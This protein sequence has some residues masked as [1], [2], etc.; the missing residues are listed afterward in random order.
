M[1]VKLI[2]Y[3]FNPEETVNSAAA[4]CYNSKPNDKI[5]EHCLKSRHFSVLEFA[6]FDFLI[7]GISRSCSHQFVR[8]RVGISYAQQSQ[9]HVKFEEGY[10]VVIPHTISSNE[11]ALKI[12]N[13][14]HKKSEESYKK[15][16][17]IGIPAED[18]RYVIENAATT[19]IRANMNGRCLI[20]F[21]S[22]RL[23]SK[24]QWE[25][26]ELLSKIRDEV[27]KVSPIIAK[28]MQ[29]KCYWL[30]HCPESKSCGKWRQF[31]TK[32]DF[33]W[34]KEAYEYIENVYEI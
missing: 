10:D 16:L 34:I 2:N 1:Y 7:T 5:I 19:V 21:A 8:K 11:E 12:F 17:E 22:E 33:K 20:D 4:V 28:S 3:T 27:S 9:R 14:S 6:D 15:L 18:A 24:A 32:E 31:L 29:P 25:I 13:D 30:K 26:R 23:C